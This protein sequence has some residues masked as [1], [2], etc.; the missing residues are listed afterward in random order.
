VI[1]DPQRLPQRRL[2]MELAL[3]A[4]SL[5][6]ACEALHRIADELRQDGS[7]TVQ[8]TSG[9]PAYGH[10]LSMNVTDPQMD[11]GRYRLAVRNWLANRMA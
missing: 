6:D 9:R 3:H 7:E 10:G 5:G 4:D 1:T 2:R 11:G 8:Q